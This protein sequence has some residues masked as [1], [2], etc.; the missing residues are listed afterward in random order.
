MIFDIL[1]QAIGFLAMACF[2]ISF[3]I[4]SN[5]LLFIVQISGSVMFCIQYLMLGA[6]GGCYNF[7]IG[8]VRNILLCIRDK[9][10]WAA[11]NGWVVI[12]CAASV[13]I[14]VFTWKGLISILPTIAVFA[15]TIGYWMDNARTIRLCNL[16]AVSP[17]WLI[18]GIYA[19]SVGAVLNEVVVLTSII[20]SIYRYGWKNL[21]DADFGKKKKED[22]GEYNEE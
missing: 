19:G 20:I 15:G 17:A 11:W 7:I 10:K 18:Y 22:S 1:V 13:V 8:I 16:V 2:I 3:Q 9:H 14:M 21:G 5:K 4:R 6:V 12:F